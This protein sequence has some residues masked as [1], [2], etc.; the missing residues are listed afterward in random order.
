[1]K[2]FIFSIALLFLL[3]PTQV[4]NAAYFIGERVPFNAIEVDGALFEWNFPDGI[5]KYGQNVTHIFQDPGRQEVALFV[6]KDGKANA[7]TTIVTIIDNAFPIGDITASSTTSSVG[8]DIQLHANFYDQDDDEL[9]YRWTVEKLF[10]ETPE[11]LLDQTGANITH[12]FDSHG[13]Y[14]IK[15]YVIDEVSTSFE[16][17]AVEKFVYINVT[18]S[19]KDSSDLKTQNPEI[20]IYFIDPKKSGNTD[21]VFSFYPMTNGLDNNKTTY[22]WD[23]GDNSKYTSKNTRHRYVK[24]GI[25]NVRVTA[26]DSVNSVSTQTQ[27]SV[28]PPPPAKSSALF[29]TVEENDNEIKTASLTQ[30]FQ[31]IT[32]NVDT[33]EEYKIRLR[34]GPK[35]ASHVHL[36]DSRGTAQLFFVDDFPR[37][38]SVMN[39]GGKI[40]TLRIGKAAADGVSK[41]PNFP[42]IANQ[43]Q[44]WQAQNPKAATFPF[45]AEI[46]KSTALK[47]FAVTIEYKIEPPLLPSL[48]YEQL[49]IWRRSD[50]IDAK[51]EYLAQFLDEFLPVL[52]KKITKLSRYNLK[53]L[54]QPLKNDSPEMNSLCSKP[55]IVNPFFLRG[56]LDELLALKPAQ[57]EAAQTAAEKAKIQFQARDITLQKYG[58]FFTNTPDRACLD[59][60]YVN[61]KRLTSY[62]S[63]IEQYKKNLP[64][65]SEDKELK[66]DLQRLSSQ[67]AHLKKIITET[68]ADLTA[69]SKSSIT[70]SA[71]IVPKFPHPALF[72]WDVDG[73]LL[74]GETVTFSLPKPGTYGVRVR[75]SEGNEFIYDT[76]NLKILD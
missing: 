27:I 48:L 42:L 61:L 39:A 25:Y 19:E 72:E 60:T 31:Y 53:T 36:I 69:K 54:N 28:A 73:Q 23:M 20:A 21:T 33:E 62:L 51:S 43:L 45:I 68:P 52:E 9:T 7:T 44:V 8:Q 67:I 74:F 14:R 32:L 75:V 3:L 13:R 6:E 57:F 63:E 15:L 35:G 70:L 47:E 30:I 37:A 29:V 71:S 49:N 24:P 12:K 55:I 66:G 16:T 59:N 64:E 50:A 10:S 56:Q 58:L 76:I 22:K 65:I 1:M 18:K 17:K 11:T 5:K 34:K 41:S 46:L 40:K 2:N 38:I 26:S 4:S